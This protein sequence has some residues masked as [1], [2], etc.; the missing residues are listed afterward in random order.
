MGY[1]HK[2]R[3]VTCGH[4]TRR[5][6]WFLDTSRKFS[7]EWLCECG[8]RNRLKPM[9]EWPNVPPS[10]YIGPDVHARFKVYP[11]PPELQEQDWAQPYSI[12]SFAY[13]ASA[14]F[15]ACIYRPSGR[16]VVMGEPV[17]NDHCYDPGDI[18]EHHEY[19]EL[20]SPRECHLVT[21]WTTGQDTCGLWQR[22]E[23]LC[24]TD[25]ERRFLK[26]YLGFVKDR[27]FP[28]LIPQAWL[29]IADRRRPD[30]VAFVPLQYWKYRWLAIQLDAAHPEESAEADAARDDYV[31]S[32][33]YE[34]LSLRPK[35]T[36]YI[37]EVRNVVEQIDASM[38]LGN[39]DP[40]KVVVDATVRSFQPPP[41]DGIPF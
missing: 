19:N 12:R 14:K 9:S 31:R 36:G 37:E 22:I 39:T 16:G 11:A 35:Q 34:V 27:E 10:L 33:N 24:Q 7:S 21:G 2:A 3:A 32:Q 8:A 38:A 23:T 41:D 26:T 25:S 20:S 15:G 40:W 18:A 4:C 17:F 13:Q 6:A 29:G 5:V 1:R 28:M 30:F